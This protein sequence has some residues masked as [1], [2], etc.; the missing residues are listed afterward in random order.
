ML[1]GHNGEF[2]CNRPAGPGDELER[3]GRLHLRCLAV[4]ALRGAA[5]SVGGA[6]LVLWTWLPQFPHLPARAVEACG[7]LAILLPG[8]GLGAL[9]ERYGARRSFPWV[10]VGAVVAVAWRLAPW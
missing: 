5:A 3:I 1:G 10:A 9:I 4:T 7:L 6:L 2:R 8:L